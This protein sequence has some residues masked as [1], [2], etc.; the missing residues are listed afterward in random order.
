M[1]LAHRFLEILGTRGPTLF[2]S[3]DLGFGGFFELGPR[4]RPLFELGAWDRQ[5]YY[6]KSLRS[7]LLQ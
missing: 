3:W 1:G 4:T 5:L 2:G 6:C 7:N